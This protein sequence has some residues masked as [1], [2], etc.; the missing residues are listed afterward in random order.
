MVLIE[1]Y[2]GSDNN[3]TLL[4]NQL[5]LIGVFL[6]GNMDVLNATHGCPGISYLNTSEIPMSLIKY[7]LEYLSLR[8]DP[9]TP[10]WLH[11]T[12]NS[13]S[14]MKGLSKIIIE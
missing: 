8:M 13:L 11:D 4:S 7:G 5:S 9:D 3:L 10:E 12:L 1:Y 6:V 2:G 14:S